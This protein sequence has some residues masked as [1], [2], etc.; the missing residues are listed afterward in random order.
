MIRH[1]SEAECEDLPTAHS[2]GVVAA[3]ALF[4]SIG[5]DLDDA[6]NST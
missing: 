3:K 1:L 5:D 6:E 2:M 4:F